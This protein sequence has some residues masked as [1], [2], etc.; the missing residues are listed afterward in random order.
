MQLFC[1]QRIG[2]GASDGLVNLAGNDLAVD[3]RHLHLGTEVLVGRKLRGG[4]GGGMDARQ[5]GPDG[6]ITE[7]ISL[8]VLDADRAVGERTRARQ[9]CTLN[10]ASSPLC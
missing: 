6:W 3:G 10:F 4:V 7:G 9:Y 8:E 2:A 1:R 5:D